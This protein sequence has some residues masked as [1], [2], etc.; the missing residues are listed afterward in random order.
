MLCTPADD[1]AST[2]APEV[3]NDIL[4]HS[5]EHPQRGAQKVPRALMVDFTGATGSVSQQGTLDSTRY[6]PNSRPELPSTWAG[7]VK[8]LA[9][10]S[11]EQ[12]PYQLALAAEDELVSRSLFMNVDYVGL[13]IITT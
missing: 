4:F 5:F 10:Q 7:K 2:S 8:Y 3:R 1:P 6:G 11:I 9:S 12:H 13:F